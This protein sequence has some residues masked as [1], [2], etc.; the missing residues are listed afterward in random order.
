MF[1]ITPIFPTAVYTSKLDRSLTEEENFIF[2]SHSTETTLNH[3]NTM[4]ACKDVLNAKELFNIKSFIQ[5]HLNEYVTQVYDT[6]NDIEIYI[7]QS[8]LNWTKEFQRHHV[9]K[10]ANSFLSGVFYI[11]TNLNDKIYFYK[12]GYNQIY[13]E[14]KKYNLYNSIS[15]FFPV[16]EGMLILFPSELTHGVQ[17]LPKESKT[18][19]S[20][21]FNT[22][23]KGKLGNE[24]DATL[25]QL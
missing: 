8:W 3:C 10:H 21:S 23:L 24:Q 25:L 9:H 13:L 20:L 1:S 5:K 19:I 2:N 17:Q 11:Q 18:R 22:F 4:S 12:E 14:P 7:T 15:W 6:S 16:Q